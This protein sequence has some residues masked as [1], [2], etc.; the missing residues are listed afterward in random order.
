M[1]VIVTLKCSRFE[2]SGTVIVSRRSLCPS[3]DWRIR[4]L[5][6]ARDGLIVER[7]SMGV[8]GT[9]D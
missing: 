9:A 1:S 5:A 2:P 8:N 7:L 6:P 3:I 4:S